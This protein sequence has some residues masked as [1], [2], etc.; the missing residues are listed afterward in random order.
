[1]KIVGIFL[2][3]R[4]RFAIILYTKDNDIRPVAPLIERGRLTLDMLRAN[5]VDHRRHSL[6]T[7][8]PVV[9][10]KAIKQPGFA[11]HWPRCHDRAWPNQQ[12]VFIE[13]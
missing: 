12:L 9:S 5:P 13:F 1:V 7:R 8:R 10:R 4:A 11:M 3:R 6:K 2:D